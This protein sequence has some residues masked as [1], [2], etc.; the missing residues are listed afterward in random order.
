MAEAAGSSSND[1]STDVKKKS[2][3]S[4]IQKVRI[5]K[6]NSV[7]LLFIL[8]LFIQN[9]SSALRTISNILA[10]LIFTFPYTE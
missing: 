9:F 3:K 4:W 8:V 5:R 6:V 1:T 10:I 2:K 7:Y